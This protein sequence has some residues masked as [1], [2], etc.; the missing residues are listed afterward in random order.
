MQ[1]VNFHRYYLIK[2]KI[3]SVSTDKDQTFLPVFII[4]YFLT[5]I[6]RPQLQCNFINFSQ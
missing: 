6:H 2:I 4:F 1:R 5:Q 3:D